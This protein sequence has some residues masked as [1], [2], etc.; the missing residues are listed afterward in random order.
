MLNKLSIH[1][2]LGTAIY[3]IKPIVEELSKRKIETY[4]YTHPMNVQKAA[5]YLNVKTENIFDLKYDNRI[6]GYI[7]FLIKQLIVKKTFSFQYK[8]V[9]SSKNKILKIMIHILGYLPKPNPN[10][11]NKIYNSVWVLLNRKPYYKTRNVLYITRSGITHTLNSKF[12]NIV[13]I[14]ES[15]DH[16]VKSPFFVKSKKIL[17]WNKDLLKDVKKFQNENSIIESYPLK[18]RYIDEFKRLK[19]EIAN[20]RVKE[21]IE[22]TKKYSYWLYICTFS[23]FS[24][25]NIFSDEK[26]VIARLVEIAQKKKEFVYIKPH[27]HGKRDELHS[28]LSYDNVR[29][30]I[31][32]TYS[33]MNYIFTDE[34]QYYK[35]LLLKNAK[36]I[37]NIGTTLVLEA[38]ILNDSIYQLDGSDSDWAFANSCNNY[39][40]K[41]YLNVFPS[42]IKINKKTI[43]DIGRYLEVKNNGF[44]ESLRTWI[45][46]KKSN[47]MSTVFDC[48]N[49]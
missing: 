48:F 14:V 1:A 42:V 10:K 6:Q 32:A 30:G 40:I 29:I 21:E 15:W 27:P 38:S 12:H 28:L 25:G 22:F 5:T 17:V 39:H 36:K 4:L 18:F 35:Y 20:F 11:I 41:K 16:P 46:S 34:D 26:K 43:Y 24:G 37:F 47:E 44:S 45:S 8:R 23:N 7:D 9:N 31:P 49:D 3:L 33:G 13:T 19:P 2:E